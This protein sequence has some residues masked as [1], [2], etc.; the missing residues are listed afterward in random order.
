MLTK[1]Q[2]KYV[3]MFIMG[4]AASSLIFVV[5]PTF[6][7]GSSSV[8]MMKASP[9]SQENDNKVLKMQAD[10]E[11]VKERPSESPSEQHQHKDGTN[12]PTYASSN[13]NPGSRAKPANRE[14]GQGDKRV[15][16]MPKPS[17]GGLDNNERNFLIKYFK[18]FNRILEWGMGESTKIAAAVGV[19]NMRSL[20]SDR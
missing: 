17:N 2:W 19:K 9:I 20:D 6:L 5:I 1:M 16:P 4:F 11:K 13:E 8:Q 18:K 10:H 15:Y 3:L 12:L 7:R 14:T